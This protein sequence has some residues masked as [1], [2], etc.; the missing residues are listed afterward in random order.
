MIA[1]TLNIIMLKSDP[2]VV[3]SNLGWSN[4]LFSNKI[5]QNR[6]IDVGICKIIDFTSPNRGIYGFV[7]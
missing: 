7:L 6:R 4:W 5:I 1:M 2:R 3:G